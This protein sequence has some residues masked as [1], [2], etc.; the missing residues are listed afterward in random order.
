M[1][2]NIIDNSELRHWGNRPARS[3]FDWL[4]RLVEARRARRAQAR[5]FRKLRDL[6]RATLDDIGISYDEMSELGVSLAA[7]NPYAVSIGV[8]TRSRSGQMG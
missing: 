6:D 5:E 1:L 2:T 3:V 4:K 8:I 7:S